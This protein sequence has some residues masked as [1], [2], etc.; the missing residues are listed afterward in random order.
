MQNGTGFI[1]SKYYKVRYFRYTDNTFTTLFPTG[2]ED[3][4]MHILGPEIAAEVGDR[5]IVHFKNMADRPYSIHPQVEKQLSF[6]S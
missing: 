4:H 3:E 1:G 5:V 6:F 2:P